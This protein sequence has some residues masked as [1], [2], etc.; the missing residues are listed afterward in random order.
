MQ[1]WQ[2]TIESAC[3]QSGRTVL[4]TLHSPQPLSAWLG[5]ESTPGLIL[6][7]NATKGLMEIEQQSSYRLLIGPEGGLSDAEIKQVLQNQHFQGISLG[8][9]ILRTETAA[10]TAISILQ[11]RFGDL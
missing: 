7:P 11:A 2:K 1:H 3:E 6:E 10:L 4:P 5:L 8:P 9:R